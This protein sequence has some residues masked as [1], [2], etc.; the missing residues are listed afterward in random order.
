MP[1]TI[2]NNSLWVVSTVM[3]PLA[4]RLP[5]LTR[6]V[7]FDAVATAGDFTAAARTLGISQP[8]VSRHMSALSNEL[9]IQLFERAGRSFV[10]TEEGRALATAADTAFISLERAL[11]E[12]DDRNGTFVFAVQP[13]MATTWV[14]P[15]LD[16]LE[17][18]AGAE[19]RLRIFERIAELDDRDW[20]LAIV[21]GRGDWDSWDSTML[22]HEAVRPFASPSLATE[23]GLTAQSTAADLSSLN[24]LHI[25]TD[26]RPNMTWTEWF[27]EASNGTVSPSTPRLLYNAYPTVIQEALASNGI[28]LGWQHLLSDMVERRLLVPVGPIVQR[29]RGGHYMC[30]RKGRADERHRGI[31]SFLQAEILA[32]S[33]S[34]DE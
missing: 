8:A 1:N 32:S 27:D 26:G 13:A 23:L 29:N 9:G 33:E 20:N 30:W 22:F 11:A 31:T 17:T 10:L 19:I 34:F 24:L 18:A 2:H 25:D 6:L 5:Q 7:I 3:R 21:P 12:V 28:A 4:K 14:V 15:L 16:Q